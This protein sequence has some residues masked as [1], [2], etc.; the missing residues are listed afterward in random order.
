MFGSILILSVV[1]CGEQAD[2]ARQ[3]AEKAE[4]RKRKSSKGGSKSKKAKGNSGEALKSAFEKDA[5]VRT[6]SKPIFT[7]PLVWITLG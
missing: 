5:Q 4:K 3:K 6:G 7:Q 2:K 1:I